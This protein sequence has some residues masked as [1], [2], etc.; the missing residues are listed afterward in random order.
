MANSSSNKPADQAI[1]E[2]TT[3]E[4]Q[5]LGQRFPVTNTYQLIQQT[6]HKFGKNF[7]LAQ[8]YTAEKDEMP[9]YLTFD[10]F[11][12]KTRQMAGLLKKLGVKRNDAVTILLPTLMENHIAFWGSQAVAIANPI[13]HF[14]DADL[15]CDIMNEVNSKIL[16]TLAPKDSLNLSKKASEIIAKVPGLTHVLLTTDRADKTVDIQEFKNLCLDPLNMGSEIQ[17]LDFSQALEEQ[18]DTSLPEEMPINSTD[19]AIYF[20][21]GGTTG[22]PKIAML[23]HASVS[24]VAQVYADFNHHHGPSASLNA[25]PLF[26]VFGTIAASLA[27]FLQGRCVVMMTPTGFRNPNVVKNWWHFVEY[28]KVAWFATVPTI[29][30]A[31]LE[32]PVGN[33]NIDCLKY[34]NSGSAPLSVNLKNTF[35]RKFNVTVVSGYGMT[36]SSC[37]I[38][39]CLYGYDT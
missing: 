34:V 4:K 14:L 35:A 6:K 32:I 26:H 30:N 12:R 17:I 31:L 5:A 22:K 37:L 23:S 11:T 39:R 18:A 1:N 20:H 3:Y 2:I 7:A 29:M 25:L 36:E 10:Q 15:I 28:F 33:H 16:I 38:S 24:F 8:L 13:N 19:T 27:V 9:Q 21:T